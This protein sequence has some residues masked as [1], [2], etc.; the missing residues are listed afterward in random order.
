MIIP[1][2]HRPGRSSGG[3]GPPGAAARTADQSPLST[4][5]VAGRAPLF[6]VRRDHLE[7][8][9]RLGALARPPS[10]S[11]GPDVSLASRSVDVARSLQV[12][13]LHARL[14]GWEQVSDSAWGSLAYLGE[15]L[16]DD[17]RVFRAR[18]A[19]DGVWQAEPADSDACAEDVHG[20]VVLALGEASARGP[21][22]QFRSAARLL[23]RRSIPGTRGLKDLRAI[24]SA[25]LGCD[26][27][28]RTL[29]EA[30]GLQRTLVPI[31]AARF[32]PVAWSLDWPWPEPVLTFDSA[33]SARALIV[34]GRRIADRRM[35]EM[36]LAVLEW[37]VKG[38]VA[39]RGH[40]SPVGDDGW[41]TRHG[42]RATFDQLPI[43]PLSILLAA[44]TAFLATDDRRHLEDMERSYGWFLGANDL[45]VEIADPDRGGCRDGLG[46]DG[47][48]LH[49]GAAST[50]AWLTALEHIRTS[51]RRWATAA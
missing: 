37:L 35:V 3:Q 5:P 26:A 44:E 45:G 10:R 43:E 28:R 7:S 30:A 17:S 33:L 15:A 38:A 32:E 50:L 6:D 18:R 51:R 34:A 11:T 13:L 14:L 47:A 46:P 42:E 29:D 2:P 36:G 39:P 8:L 12:D 25:I 41:W 49:Q 23:F 27:A 4:W 21:D 22:R 20:Q 1:R 9:G 31:L 40:L 16:S 24:A 48:R 19:P